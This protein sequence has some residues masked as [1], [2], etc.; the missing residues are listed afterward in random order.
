MYL[1]L[2][3]NHEWWVYFDFSTAKYF[4]DH[5]DRTFGEPKILKCT[6]KNVWEEIKWA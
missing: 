2:L 3:P 4:A 1:V 6:E 5:A